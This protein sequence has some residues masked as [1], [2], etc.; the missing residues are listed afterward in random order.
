MDLQ[1]LNEHN[2][3]EFAKF[4]YDNVNAI[5]TLEYEDDLAKIKYV[6]RLFRRYKDTGNIK[7]CLVMNHIITLYNVFT[8]P[9]NCTRM[10]MFKL[11]DYSDCLKPFL[12]F[13]NYW[14][15]EIE[16]IDNIDLIY[17]SDISLDEGIVNEIRKEFKQ[18][19]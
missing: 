7:I 6:K 11:Y 17:G 14:P 8:P 10:L 12:V 15:E 19:M 13:L 1:Y 4:S 9:M 18:V 2:F 3:H 16:K 5:D